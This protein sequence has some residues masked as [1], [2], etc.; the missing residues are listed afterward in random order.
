M[1]GIVG[2]RDIVVLGPGGSLGPANAATAPVAGAALPV[3]R[4]PRSSSPS[5]FTEFNRQGGLHPE[6][7]LPGWNDTG[8]FDPV[9]FSARLP[10]VELL[11]LASY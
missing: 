4:A 8:G 2:F 5:P 6:D 10:A 11:G 1:G 7:A 9:D 3:Y